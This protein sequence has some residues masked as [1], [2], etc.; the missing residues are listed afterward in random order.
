MFIHLL[1]KLYSAPSR[2]TIRSE[3]P[4][5][6][7]RTAFNC[8]LLHT[9]RYPARRRPFK[10][11]EPQARSQRGTRGLKPPADTVSPLT[12]HQPPHQPS[13]SVYQVWAS[14]VGLYAVYRNRILIVN[15]RFLEANSAHKAKSGNQLIHRRLSKTKS[16]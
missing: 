11:P 13:V 8:D 15:S 9:K 6:S 1:K 4:Q 2:L 12:S 16:I 3:A 14:A 5:T 10:I 7:V